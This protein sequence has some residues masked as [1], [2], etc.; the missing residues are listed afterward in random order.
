MNCIRS[1]GNDE[2]KLLRPDQACF[3]TVHRSTSVVSVSMCTDTST[4]RSPFGEMMMRVGCRMKVE[5]TTGV[6]SLA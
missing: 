4:C 5:A 1:C 3:G 6:P 2:T